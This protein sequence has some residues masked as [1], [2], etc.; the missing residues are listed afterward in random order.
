MTRTVLTAGVQV[1]SDRSAPLLFDFDLHA[2]RIAFVARDETNRLGEEWR[3]TGVYVLLGT[4]SQGSPTEIYIGQA[5]DLRSRLAHHRRK[6][7]FEW[8]RA[9]AALRDTATGFDSAQIG[10]LEGRLAR[11]LRSR[12]GVVVKEGLSSMDTTLPAFARSPLDEFV[13]TILEALRIAGLDL[14][15]ASD[16]GSEG[17]EIKMGHTRTTIPGTVAD[18]LAAGLISAGTRL[19]AER[20]GRRAEAEVSITGE[21]LVNGV[22]YKSP[23]TAAAKGL[24]VRASNGW[25]K[26]TTD[27]GVT[28][29]DLRGR[30]GSE[31][32]DEG[33]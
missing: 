7:K 6:P 33:K 23:N 17:E 11:E 2:L 8:W 10:Y 4:V 9:V 21:L 13:D 20:G 25:K 31:D 16:E 1:P 15:S 28:L 18:L 30:L 32:G 27:E 14:R 3:R 5:V 12:P 19:T 22:A 26:W 24:E 29:A